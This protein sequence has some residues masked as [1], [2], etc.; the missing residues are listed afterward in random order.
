MNEEKE[1]AVQKTEREQFSQF[2]ERTAEEVRG[3]PAW[4]QAILGL[5]QSGAKSSNA[6]N[7]G[8]ASEEKK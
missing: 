4:K 6:K 2:L 3:W 7:T 5:P 8:D 1:H